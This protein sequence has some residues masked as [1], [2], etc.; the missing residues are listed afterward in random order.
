MSTGDSTPANASMQLP[1][2]CS[3]GLHMAVVQFTQNQSTR[4]TG[5][6]TEISGHGCIQPEEVCRLIM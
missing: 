2:G 3:S 6:R 4:P 5:L 1:S